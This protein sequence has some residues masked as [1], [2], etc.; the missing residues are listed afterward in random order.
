MYY[1][2]CP[3]PMEYA[4]PQSGHEIFLLL[5]QFEF[6][7]PDSSVDAVIRYLVPAASGVLLGRAAAAHQRSHDWRGT[8]RHR[9]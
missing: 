7:K 1:V 2:V 9:T 3:M 8:A 5:H 4:P 6:R